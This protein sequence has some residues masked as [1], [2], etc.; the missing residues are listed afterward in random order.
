MEIQNLFPLLIM[1]SLSYFKSQWV[2]IRSNAALI[3]GQLY[4]QLTSENKHQVSLDTVCDRLMRLFQDEHEEVRM[5]AAQAIVY[6]F[7]N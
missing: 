2:E 7:L 5:M 4:S 6:L 1:T 3:A